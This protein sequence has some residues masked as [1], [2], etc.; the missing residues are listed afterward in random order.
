MS[1]IKD[2]CKTF[3]FPMFSYQMKVR[4]TEHVGRRSGEL[5]PEIRDSKEEE[6]I[7]ALCVDTGGPWCEIILPFDPDIN[8]VVHEVFHC[9]WQMMEYIGAQ[10]ENEIMAHLNGHAVELICKWLAAVEKNM[11]SCL[12]KPVEP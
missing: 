10:H 12:D 9:I 8:T 4:L 6:Y 5:Y 11:T 2:Q 7:D 3:K 1:S